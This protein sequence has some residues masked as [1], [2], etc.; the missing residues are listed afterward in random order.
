MTMQEK[1]KEKRPVRD[2]KAGSTGGASSINKSTTSA[3]ENKDNVEEEEDDARRKRLERE[4]R[5]ESL[6]LFVL[7]LLFV[8][9]SFGSFFALIL[10]LWQSDYLEEKDNRIPVVEFF[11]K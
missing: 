4:R 6:P 7:L 3:S 5:L 8:C 2:D 10:F 1:T 9:L 11:S